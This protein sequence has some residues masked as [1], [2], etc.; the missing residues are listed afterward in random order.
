MSDEERNRQIAREAAQEAVNQTLE[1]LG[2]DIHN[3]RQAQ[4]DF[5]TLRRIREAR[6]K[7][8]AALIW[9]LITIAASGLISLVWD[10][11]SRGG[12]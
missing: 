12:K 3:P 1:A 10:S 7:G 4:A 2:I 5:Q 9:V 8:V 11:L 6:E